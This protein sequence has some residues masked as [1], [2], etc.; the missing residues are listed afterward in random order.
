M[1]HAT[2]LLVVDDDRSIR[3]AL[4]DILGAAG[5]NPILCKDGMEALEKVHN[6][7]DIKLVLSDVSMEPMDGLELQSQIIKVRPELPVMMM[8]AYGTVD[9]AVSAIKSGAVDFMSKPF[10]VDE[11]LGKISQN[12][13]LGQPKGELCYA[14]PKMA[15]IVTLAQRVAQSEATVLI[16]GESGT[17]KEVFSRFIHENSKRAEKSFIA[18]NCAAIPDNML[19][20]ILFG[21]EKGAFTGAIKATPG[22]FELANGGTLLLDEISEMDLALQAKLLRVLQE[23][24]VDRLGSNKTIDL[25]VRI[26]AT[27]NRNL[28]EEIA[29]GKF[30]EDLYYRLNVFP[31][32]IPALKKRPL[33][34]EPLSMLLIHKHQKINPIVKKPSAAALEKMMAYHWPGNV[35]ELENVIQRA[36]VLS[37]SEQIQPEDIYFEELE[38]SSSQQ[39]ES[40]V[41]KPLQMDLKNHEYQII[42]DTLME[43]KGSRKKTSEILGISP[44]TL[45]YKLSKMKALGYS[46]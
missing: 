8:T 11:L 32:Q 44:R 6:R 19:E 7:D 30:R 27:T 43:N 40:Q 9:K 45:R 26:L 33:D 36:L 23:K 16:S 29:A 2:S 18:I 20:A 37:V 22:K 34:I 41:E 4:G 21:Y 25:D 3:T 42:F 46:M 15:Q 1:N 14:D 13:Q 28:R 35:R 17:G 10:D 12:I 31:L 38:S 39:A 24:E 5:Y